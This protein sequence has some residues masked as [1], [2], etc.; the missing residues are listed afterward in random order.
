MKYIGQG[1]QKLHHKQS[2]QTHTQRDKTDRHTIRPNAYQTTFTVVKH[3]R[4]NI[5][6]HKQKQKEHFKNA[7]YRKI[8]KKHSYSSS[9]ADILLH[10]SSLMFHIQN[11]I[12]PDTK[13][14]P[15]LKNG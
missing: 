11:K 4:L 8:Q 10:H 12:L 6:V 15:Y 14:Q 5:Q 3:N 2:G 13:N 1:L 7:E 9:S